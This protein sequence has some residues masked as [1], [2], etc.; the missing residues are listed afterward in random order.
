MRVTLNGII[1]ADDDAWL[2]EFFGY[3]AFSPATIRQALRDNPEGE[4]LVLEINSGGGS[5]FAGFEMYS[6][7]RASGVRTRAEIQSLAASAAST[8]AMGC[9]EVWISPV[10]EM[11]IHLPSTCTEGDRNEHRQSIHVLDTIAESILNGYEAKSGGKRSREE[12]SRMMQASTWLTAQEA[13]DAGLVDGILFQDDG[14][15][16]GN[17]VNAVGC[18]LRAIA[19]SG[20]L[21]DPEQLRAQYRAMQGGGAQTPP[22][23]PGSAGPDGPRDGPGGESAPLTDDWMAKARLAIEKN[24]FMEV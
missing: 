7:L 15:L 12:L 1:A 5:V 16:P 8:L 13:L 24:R 11:M 18:G 3:S 22:P 21:P 10:A 6:V 23:A 17:I 4:D 14:P 2:Y 19:G 9:G 20:G